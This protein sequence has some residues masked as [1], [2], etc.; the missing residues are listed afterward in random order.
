MPAPNEPVP[1]LSP[2]FPDSPVEHG[3]MYQATFAE[4]I[5][6]E[7]GIATMAVG[8]ILDL[9]HA[10]TVLAAGRADLCAIARAHLADP[11]LTLHEAA[12]YGVDLPWPGQ[13]L[14]GKPLARR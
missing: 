2:R 9:D 4:R 5:R 14:A 1:S 13:Y 3:R 6:H 10:N 11:F 8:G 12:R 7:A